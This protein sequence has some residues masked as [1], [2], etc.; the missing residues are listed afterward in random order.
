L[1]AS[2]ADN[3]YEKIHRRVCN[4]ENL[5]CFRMTHTDSTFLRNKDGDHQMNTW[6]G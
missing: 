5:I 1:Q 4:L 3:R 6:Q 2:T